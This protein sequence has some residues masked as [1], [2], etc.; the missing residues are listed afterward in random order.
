MGYSATAKAMKVLDT[1][2]SDTGMSNTWIRDGV[3]HFF[4]IG[5]ENADGSITGTV[6]RGTFGDVRAMGYAYRQGSFKI[7][8]DGHILR[9]PAGMRQHLDEQRGLAEYLKAHE[10]REA[11]RKAC[12]F[13]NIPADSMFVVFSDSNPYAA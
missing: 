4:E 10:P 6:W 12:E 11:W 13:D 9:A 1:F 3:A 5:R 8:A 2:K 7:D